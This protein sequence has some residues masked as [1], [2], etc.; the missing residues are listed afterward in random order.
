MANEQIGIDVVARDMASA[1]LDR[2][3][4][5]VQG[6]TGHQD[7]ASASSRG[8][9]G[10]VSSMASGA[11]MGV[12]FAAFNAITGVVGGFG[13]AVFGMNASLETST[14]QFETLMGDTDRAREHVEGLFDFAANTPFE[15]EPIINASRIMQTFGGDALNTKENLTL[16]GD[17][18]A[19]TSTNIDEIGFWMSRAYA[20]IQ[21]G[22][23]FGEARM[24]LMELGVITPQVAAEIDSL[25]QSGAST[26]EVWGAMS[27]SLDRFGGAMERQASTWDGTLSTFSDTVKM[28]LADA[29]R[30]LFEG[31]KGAIQWFNEFA[32]SPAIEDLKNVFGQV[33]A[34]AFEM[35]GQ[36]I[37]AVMPAIGAIGEGLGSFLAAV[38]P[39]LQRLGESVGP[40]IGTV[41]AKLGE[42]IGD[43]APKIGPIAAAL[44]ELAGVI[45]DQL[46]WGFE[47]IAPLIGPVL[48]IFGALAGVLLDLLGPAIGFVAGILGGFFEFIRPVAEFLVSILGPAF[49]IVADAIGGFGE[50]VGQVLGGVED[51]FNTVIGGIGDL[52]SGFIEPIRAVVDIAAQLDP[53]GA[54]A[55]LRDQIDGLQDS[56][57]SWGTTTDDAST[58]AG[59]FADATAG[60][61]DVADRASTTVTGNYRDMSANVTESA[62][63]TGRTVVGTWEDTAAGSE[64]AFQGG[65]D[66][67]SGIA[68]GLPGDVAR[69]IAQGQ[70]LI[71]DAMRD[72][73]DGLVTESREKV[74]H[75]LQTTGHL[76]PEMSQAFR[77]G[78][79]Q[80]GSAMETA[81]SGMDP[82]A[83][84]AVQDVLRTVGKTPGEIAESLRG[85]RDLVANGADALKD[86]FKSSISPMK[87]ISQLEADLTSKAMQR[88]LS[89]GDPM[90][91]AEAQSWKANIEDRLFALRNGVDEFALDTGMNYAD[92]LA[93]KRGAVDNAA[94][95]LT[96]AVQDELTGLTPR[97]NPWGYATA[98]NYGEGINAG[99][100]YVFG[101]V[102]DIT[103]YVAGRLRAD[104]PPRDPEIRPIGEWGRRTIEE[105]A[106][107]LAGGLPKVIDSV[108]SVMRTIGNLGGL[109]GSVGN[110]DLSVI[111]GGTSGPFIPP[112]PF[113][114]P[115][116]GDGGY[117]TNVVRGGD[118]HLHFGRDSV[119]SDDDIRDISRRIGEEM[120]LRYPSGTP[121]AQLG[122]V[123]A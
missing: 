29:M 1:E 120:R 75:A 54:L 69:P 106:Y 119:R 85:G 6:L 122:V 84:E 121:G 109:R 14:L 107:G 90:V 80:V 67:L 2:V 123:V 87:E 20:A 27:G 57:E 5:S 48:D 102:N 117:E 110:V 103:A 62:W 34:Q 72:M 79:G 23:P 73:L 96:D 95:D 42:I 21:G 63:E 7:T 105:Y 56:L 59:G 9:A 97:A 40:I 76:T 81:L 18:A 26:E 100:A 58:A 35:L 98:H 114:L 118:I 71:D 33:L 43:L 86:A 116:R 91:R 36:G 13:D 41:F 8:L 16:F 19:A 3:G 50:I 30:P 89:H 60:L 68:A 45:I 17:A 22:Q 82:A 28:F 92:A 78:E 104:S 55:G 77:A 47:L 15:T 83:R 53:T 10:S 38:M 52:I 46:A 49:S 66:G 88:G 113:P 4:G 61:A 12:G 99:T 74:E 111:P 11:L 112:A 115:S 65:A 94:G 51:A 64:A 108:G 37:D 70:P 24:R 32:S 39:A 101:Q 25:S 93:A 31:I 44:G